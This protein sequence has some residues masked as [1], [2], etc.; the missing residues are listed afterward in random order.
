MVSWS[1]L[2]GADC[3]ELLSDGSGRDSM[4]V[5]WK[6]EDSRFSQALAAD[7]DDDDGASATEDPR[8]VD[9]ADGV[10]GAARVLLR[11]WATVLPVVDAAA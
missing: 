6:S 10:L 7:D 3:A 2:N 9:A 4:Y 8:E 5:A 1:F 11:V